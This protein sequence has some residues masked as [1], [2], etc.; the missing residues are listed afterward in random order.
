MTLKHITYSSVFALFLMVPAFAHAAADQKPNLPTDVAEEAV[1]DVIEPAIVSES[2]AEAAGDKAHDHA[3]AGEHTLAHQEWP[4][5]GIFGMY[6]RASLQRGFQIYREVCSACHS[7]SRV[8]YRNL[9]DLGY[10]EAEIKAIAA[11]AQITDGPNDEGE[12]FERPGKPSDHL[13]SPY[14]NIQAA[15]FAN[16]GAYPPDM[17]LLVKSRE[18][19]ADY[20]YGILTGYSEPP[21]GKELLDGQHWNNVMHGNIIAMAPP[22]T[23][24]RVAYGDGTKQTVEQYAY[25]V[26]QFLAWAS[27]PH[28]EDR[29]RIGTK[30][31]L[32]FLVLTGVLYGVKRKVW[33][34]VH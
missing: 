22:L 14:P 4:F 18:G 8:S 33:A 26:S 3:A 7:M 31:F 28:M 19:G 27:E 32:F 23:P 16:G 29:K 1:A 10:S 6:D 9:S 30:V 12:M 20:V 17:S 11:D 15:K 5:D 34:N 25:D 21:A 13:K 24:D 2:G